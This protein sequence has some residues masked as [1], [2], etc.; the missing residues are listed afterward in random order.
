MFD[1]LVNTVF[2][3]S[4]IFWIILILSILV[5]IGFSIKIFLLNDTPNTEDIK[6][7]IIKENIDK[8]IEYKEKNKLSVVC[9]DLMC[10]IMSK[11]EENDKD[12]T[13]KFNKINYNRKNIW[14]IRKVFMKME[15]KY[16]AELVVDLSNKLEELEYDNLPEEEGDEEDG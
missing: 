1:F 2:L 16:L 11:Y 6:Q 3:I 12:C 7:S 10:D 4:I 14:N 9:S 13:I 5:L 8:D 15:Y